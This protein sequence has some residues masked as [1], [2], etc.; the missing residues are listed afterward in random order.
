M[1][2]AA[3]R[4]FLVGDAGPPSLHDAPVVA[5][6]SARELDVLRLVADGL[7]NDTI[8]ARLHLSTRTVERHLQNVY[9]KL[10]LRGRSARAAAVAR[11]F[12]P[13]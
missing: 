12:A 6:L 10:D 3:V 11:L 8:A 1:F 9:A 4:S 2:V 13:A 5:G 7:D